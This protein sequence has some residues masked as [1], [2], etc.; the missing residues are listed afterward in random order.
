[1]SVPVRHLPAATE[2]LGDVVLHPSFADDAIETER[3]LALGEV[4]RARDDM[5]R[6]PMRLATLAAYGAHPYARSV[7]G[8]EDSL[9]RITGDEAGKLQPQRLRIV[10]AAA[11]ETAEAFAGRMALSDRPLEWFLLLNGLDRPGA[12][13]AG[14][15]FSL[16]LLLPYRQFI[17]E[18]IDGGR[19]AFAG[20]A[21][22]RFRLLQRRT[23]RLI[24]RRII[25][26]LPER[27]D[28]IIEPGLVAGLH[29]FDKGGLGEGLAAGAVALVLVGHRG[30]RGSRNGLRGEAGAHAAQGQHAEGQVPAWTAGRRGQGSHS[31]ASCSSLE[32]IVTVAMR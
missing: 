28:G 24:G 11:G 30:R 5:Y 19:T 17:S 22:H 16:Q 4:T 10:S 12:L 3:T 21:G 23:V 9:R 14:E 25:D 8:S 1:M 20:E 13:K 2:L 29:A 18:A 27:I 6:W 15:R 31:F 7:L 32:M 26:R